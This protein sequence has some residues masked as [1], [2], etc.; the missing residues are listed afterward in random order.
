VAADL[1]VPA[2]SLRG[3]R[4]R[5]ADYQ[6]RGKL[7]RERAEELGRLSSRISNFRG[8]SFGV[9]LIALLVAVFGHGSPVAMALA[10]L[11]TLAFAVLVVW[12]ARVFAEEDLAWRWWRVNQNAEARCSD[13]WRELPDDGVEFARSDH[14]YAGDLDVFGPGSL[15]QM[16]SVAHTPHGKRT[17]A[18]YL[19]GA[20][21]LAALAER[22]AAGKALAPELELRQELEALSLGTAR[23][24][25][26]QSG[27]KSTVRDLEALLEW[28][29]SA[30]RLS[31]RP[32]LVW[33]ARVLP[34][35]FFAAL[36]A[37]TLF[38]LSPLVWGA[39]LLLQMMITTQ[40][41]GEAGRVFNIV[42]AT[43]GA[44]TRF[45][46]TFSRLETASFD[47]PLLAALKQTLNRGGRPA[48]AQMR[49]FERALG[50]F[51]LRHNG[52]VYPFVTLVTLWDVH[53]VVALERWQAE[54]GK[55][56]RS[57]FEALGQFEA[58][59]S[60]AGLAYDNP[61]FSFPEIT[62]EAQFDAQGLGHP[63]IAPDSRV[64]NDVALPGPGRA[65]LVTGSNM[66]GKSTLLRAMGV[67]AVMALAGA[68]VCARRLRIGLMGVHT[69]MRISDSLSAGVSHFYAEL[70]KLHS[71]LLA[72]SSGLPVFFLLDEIL[73]GTNSEERQIGARWILAELIRSG[74]LGA[75][76][77]HDLGLCQLPEPLSSH[78]QSVHFRETVQDGKMTFDYRLRRGPVTG[79][80]ALRLM[81]SL[82][83]EVPLPDA[84]PAQHSA[85]S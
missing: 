58:M 19:A 72:T 40:A 66:S 49:R 10:L 74:A 78:V 5:L 43:Q 3:R 30:P 7:H 84:E 48:S 52:M 33:G 63:L 53:C 61:E 18:S 45:K 71:T 68:P 31:Q 26:E 17:L 35:L 69:S 34:P 81:R 64:E 50:W 24:P 11:G 51:E 13:A 16:M 80:N 46:P 62:A 28:A 42:S 22:Q 36:L 38:D 65:L 55:S 2:G 54:T 47:T 27:K 6:A 59:S 14:P 75:V 20:G 77:T 41:A 76:S 85:L 1:V 79:G 73:H 82:G 60:L 29:E 44:F 12:H 23:A 8:L 67:A 39:L 15:F 25:H 57:W 9:A 83:L 4:Q 37:S 56:L 21:S 32:L 70:K